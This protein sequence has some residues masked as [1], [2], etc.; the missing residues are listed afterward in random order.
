LNEASAQRERARKLFN[1]G[2]VPRSELDAVEMRAATLANTCAGARQRLQAALIEHR[3]KYTNTVTEVE[4]AQSDLSAEQ[5]EIGKLRGELK[6]MRELIGTLAVRRGLLDRKN[7]QFKLVAPRSGVIFGEDLP[8]MLGQ[9]FVKGTEICRIADTRQMLLRINV[10]EREIGD[11]RSGQAVRLKAR[12]FPDHVFH[13]VVSRISGESETDQNGQAS[14]R[15]E[16][17]IEN[18]DG[19]LRPGM[20]GFARIYFDRQ[21]IGRIIWHKLKQ[22]LRPE[23]WML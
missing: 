2:I 3:R 22:S 11:V 21:M 18:A 8:K 20:T 5:K 15:V 6:T 19:L 12:S 23:L 14:Y 9:F 7:A 4:L 16:L 17:T 1:E 13:G 10:P